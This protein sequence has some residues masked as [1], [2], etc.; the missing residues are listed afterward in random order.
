M[1]SR[2]SMLSDVNFGRASDVDGGGIILTAGRKRAFP[3]SSI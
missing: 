1:H 2:T 3:G